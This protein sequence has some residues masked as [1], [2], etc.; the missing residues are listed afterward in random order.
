[1]ALTVADVQKFFGSLYGGTHTPDLNEFES[2]AI[3]MVARVDTVT[4]P[5]DKAL[6][7]LMLNHVMSAPRLDPA[8]KN[9]LSAVVLMN[10]KAPAV[11]SFLQAFPQTSVDDLVK[12]AQAAGYQVDILS[13]TVANAVPRSVVGR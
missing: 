12:A 11:E 8:K 9:A 5:G 6:G 3:R 13:P 10:I 7:L 1:M 2:A 4:A